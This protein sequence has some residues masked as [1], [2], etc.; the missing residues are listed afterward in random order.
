MSGDGPGWSP[1]GPTDPMDRPID[2][3]VTDL[4]RSTLIAATARCRSMLAS[5]VKGPWV[6]DH[7]TWIAMVAREEVVIAINPAG[8]VTLSVE[9]DM[10]PTRFEIDLGPGIDRAGATTTMLRTLRSL[11]AA[12][13]DPTVM[14]TEHALAPWYSALAQMTADHGAAWTGTMP[15]PWC[16]F[17]MVDDMGSPMR[18]RMP[19][20]EAHLL[21]RALPL[22]VMVRTIEEDGPHLSLEPV[23][24]HD[25]TASGRRDPMSTMR[26]LTILKDRIEAMTGRRDRTDDGRPE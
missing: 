24:I 5:A 22:A 10:E 2:H 17:G 9:T 15:T 8:T 21:D 3:V 19:M 7:R 12:M 11:A 1:D 13:D 25:P 16:G 14:S 20:D 6:E 23:V 4:R 26:R 18:A